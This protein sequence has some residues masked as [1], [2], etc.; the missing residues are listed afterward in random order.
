MRFEEALIQMREGKK[1]RH[2][3][4]KDGEYWVCGYSNIPGLP[5]FPV[6]L[7]V[8]DGWFFFHS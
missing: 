4:M 7:K 5:Q 2:A 1:A 8:F 6:L 3:R